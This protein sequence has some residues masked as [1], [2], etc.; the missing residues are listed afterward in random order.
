MDFDKIIAVRTNKTVYRNGNDC[1]KVFGSD[2]RKSDILNE[3]LNQARVEETGLC[4][5]HIKAVTVFDGKWAIVTDFIKGKTLAEL[6]KEHP[7]KKERVSRT[8]SGH[9][10]RYSFA[11]LSAAYQA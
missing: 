5:P 1:I 8:F 9:S 11:Y 7:E 4:I 10:A 3:A 6:M 2:F